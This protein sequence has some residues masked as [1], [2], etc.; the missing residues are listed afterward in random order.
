MASNRT[1]VIELNRASFQ[2]RESLL[3]EHGR[4]KA[5]GFRFPSG[6]AGLRLQNELGELV[7]LPF[8]GQQIWSASF[9]GRE[10]TMRSMIRQPAPTQ[11]FLQTFGGFMQHCG[12]TGMGSP[13]PDDD[14][15]L[16]GELPNAPYS[17]AFLLAG[18]D[19]QGPF[20][21]LGGEYEYARAFGYHYLAKPLARLHAGA[22]RMQISME[23]TN[24]G[25]RAM[26]L[27]VLFHINY[28]P[29]DGARL[30]YSTAY[31]PAHLRVRTSLPGHVRAQ[32]GYAAFIELLREQPEKYLILAPGQIYDPEVVFFVYYFADT[33]GWAFALQVHPD[34][35]S[36]LVRHHPSQ[37]PHGIRW[38]CRT[39]DQDAL[40]FEAGTAEVEGRA[41]EAQKGNLRWLQP[42][43]RFACD[44]EAGVCDPGE[45]AGLEKHIAAVVGG[46]QTKS[47]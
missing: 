21:A 47:D 43:S 39:P 18:E 34:G 26:P 45:T 16:H 19:A 41:R 35:S 14:H 27:M 1:K 38:I 4:I 37:L 29:V 36:D 31:D 40:G 9:L 32:P 15:P 13:G 17:R 46:R 10:L 44:W 3:V 7:L 2:D 30:V 25:G 8:Q 20:L 11:D 12:A 24:L 33:D 42:G 28:R 23:I 5:S 22:T 6:V